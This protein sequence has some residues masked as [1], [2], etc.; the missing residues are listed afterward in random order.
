MQLSANAVASG[1][2]ALALMV[3]P[4]VSRAE[5]A[6]S[7]VYRLES[8]RMLPGCEEQWTFTGHDS[9][10]VRSGEA[11]IH[12]RW[13]FEHGKRDRW[14][15]VEGLESNGQTDCSGESTADAPRHQG[16]ASIQFLHAG[17]VMLC[18][19]N[20]S[21]TQGVFIGNCF[22]KLRKVEEAPSSQ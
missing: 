5:P 13:R 3:E 15:F 21:I 1:L 9:L 11:V 16:R 22:A 19:P 7:G 18:E 8:E 17:D 4:G 2:L 20:R 6:F 14:L 10:I 12:L